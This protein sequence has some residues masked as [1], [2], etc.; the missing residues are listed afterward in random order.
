MIFSGP[1]KRIPYGIGIWKQE[2]ITR[3]N[4]GCCVHL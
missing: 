2:R 1:S 4:E 3:R